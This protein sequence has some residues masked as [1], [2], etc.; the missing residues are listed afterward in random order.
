MWGVLRAI[1]GIVV[2]QRI[3]KRA[4]AFHVSCVCDVV[5][6]PQEQV[7]RHQLVVLGAREQMGAWE[8]IQSEFRA[9]LAEGWP[10]S[11]SLKDAEG[12]QRNADERRKEDEEEGKRG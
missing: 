5:E 11:T 4:H 7:K 9:E 1:S 3:L 8:Q 12:I 10:V 2:Y 6:Q